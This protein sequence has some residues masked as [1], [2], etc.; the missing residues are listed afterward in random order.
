[1]APSFRQNGATLQKSDLKHPHFRLEA[2][3]LQN[4]RSRRLSY[5]IFFLRKKTLKKENIEQDY[6]SNRWFNFVNAPFVFKINLNTIGSLTYKDHFVFEKKE[7]PFNE[8]YSLK[9]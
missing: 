1:M 5:T 9:H 4:N 6:F 7:T 2:Q 8:V 3:Q